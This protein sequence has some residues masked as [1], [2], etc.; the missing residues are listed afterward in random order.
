MIDKNSLNFWYK[1]KD[2]ISWSKKPKKIISKVQ[3]YYHWFPDGK[4]NVYF[5][6]IKKNVL[7]GLGNKTALI[8]IDENWSENKI[9]YRELDNYV[10]RFASIIN[11][12]SK[13]SNQ[14]MIHG[15]ASLETSISMF[16][17]AKLGITHTVIF[18]ELQSEA[19]LKRIKL[20]KPQIIITRTKDKKNLD[21][22]K[23]NSKK[24]NYKIIHF[25]NLKLDKS[26]FNLNIDDIIRSKCSRSSSKE[27][28][29]NHHLFNLFTSGSTGEPKGITHSSAGYLI[30]SKFSCQK[31]FGMKKNSIMFCVSDAGWINGH[32]YSLYGPLSIGA[33]SIIMEKPI[34]I[35]NVKKFLKVLETHKVTILY[36]P[37]TLIR[38]LKSIDPN[39]KFRSKNLKTLGSMGEPLASSIAKWYAISFVKKNNPI[40]NT[41]FQTETGGIIFSPEFNDKL[42]NKTYGTVGRPIST[43]LKLNTK[44]KQ[45]LIELKIKTIWPGCMIN[46]INGKK[47]WEK[48]WDKNGYFNLF[49]IGK[50]NKNNCLV[51]NGRSDDVINIRGHRIGSEEIESIILKIKNVSEVSAVSIK[52]KIEGHKIV[53]FSSINSK[54]FIKIEKKINDELY[55]NF[56][57]YALPKKIFFL[58]SL[59][60]TRSGKI[61]RR[62]LRDLLE[63]P[64]KKINNISTILNKKIIFEIKKEII[65]DSK[66][67]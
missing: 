51:I 54:N 27:I 48:Y 16:S 28:S 52:D 42:K 18:E 37:V 21:F 36:L 60:K 56:G 55:K 23:K 41:Y 38:M 59:P 33:T 9:T 50:L 66:S 14:I 67:K 62:I 6:C 20:L 63:N 45:K 31:K 11:K 12:K 7:K 24:Y 25:Q 64:N 2:L 65:K 35:L 44:I 4:T 22:F 13:N 57:S 8:T 29:S 3:N 15:S 1:K 46:V 26:T 30:Y 58:S 43:Y 49:D 17:C 10:Q 19:I 53:I 32:T 5:N 61:M 39:I 47:I 40:V 34:S